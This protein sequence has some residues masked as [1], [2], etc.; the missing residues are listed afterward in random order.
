MGAAGAWTWLVQTGEHPRAVALEALAERLGRRQRDGESQVDRAQRRGD[1][2]SQLE[3]VPQTVKQLEADLVRAKPPEI[4]GQLVDRETRPF[5]QGS[6]TSGKVSTSHVGDEKAL[7]VGRGPEWD[8]R[9]APDFGVRR[10]QAPADA[11]PA[12][13]GR[14]RP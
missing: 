5:A 13:R 12:G 7:A 10:G 11:L 9:L 3:R 4:V 14:G 6:S 2:S 1:V 8:S